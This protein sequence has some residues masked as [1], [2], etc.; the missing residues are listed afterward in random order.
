[1]IPMLGKQNNL[2][3]VL[4]VQMESRKKWSVNICLH[5]LREQWDLIGYINA[6]STDRLFA[7]F[8]NS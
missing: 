5:Y 7:V 2:A 1:M 8:K 4:P 3:D 6:G